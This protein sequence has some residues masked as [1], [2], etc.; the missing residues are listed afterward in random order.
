MDVGLRFMNLKSRSLLSVPFRQFPFDWRR[1]RKHNLQVLLGKSWEY[2]RLLWQLL[3]LIQCAFV[4][5]Y[6][7]CTLWWT[8]KVV[9]CWFTHRSNIV[10]IEVV[11]HRW[12]FMYEAFWFRVHQ[13]L[14]WSTRLYFSL[15][16]QVRKLHLL[17]TWL[18]AWAHGY[19]WHFRVSPQMSIVFWHIRVETIHR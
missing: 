11:F 8:L 16:K 2:N 14:S 4:I 6:F 9:E 1:L 3:I 18:Q 10:V 12:R 15:W 19:T 7:I 5:W 17:I 13:R